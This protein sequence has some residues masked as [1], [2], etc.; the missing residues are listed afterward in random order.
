MNS[1]GVFFFC[2]T[3]AYFDSSKRAIPNTLI[4]LA[5][6]FAFAA[7]TSNQTLA[8]A[9]FLFFFAL[10]FSLIPYAL[11]AWAGG[12]A[13]LY[14]LL[15]AMLPLF[16]KTRAEDALALFLVSALLLGA[17]LL[18][19][20]LKGERKALGLGFARILQIKQLKNGSEKYLKGQGSSFAH[21]LGFAFALTALL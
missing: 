6:A 10:A 9:A 18:I 15:S 12:D 3:A 5:L 13:K 7:N 2:A 17:F 14:A 20:A 19:Q 8:Q 11:G 4:A 16:G 21:F 1:A